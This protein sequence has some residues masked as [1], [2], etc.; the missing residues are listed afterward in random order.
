MERGIQTLGYI[1]DILSVGD[2]SEDTSTIGIYDSYWAQIGSLKEYMT[3]SFGQWEQYR[4]TLETSLTSTAYHVSTVPTRQRGRPK[5]EIRSEQ[6][7]YLQSMSFTWTQ[8][9]DLLGVSR[10]TLHRRCGQFGLFEEPSRST[11]MS[12]SELIREMRVEFPAMGETLMWG[13]LKSLGCNVTREQ[14]RRSIRFT[15]PLH[16]ALRSP[17]AAV[18]RRPYSVPGPKHI[19]K[20]HCPK[21]LALAVMDCV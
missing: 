3:E 19:G 17:L 20:L 7:V 1:Q 10:T 6:I 9:A 11:R 14:V 15:D 4:S 2:G 18:S 5:F 21:Y 12:D 16:T 13:R 8:I